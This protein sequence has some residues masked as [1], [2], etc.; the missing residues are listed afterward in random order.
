MILR[1][2]ALLACASSAHAFHGTAR[3][4]P[5]AAPQPPRA[6]PLRATT[7]D[8]ASGLADTQLVLN[9]ACFGFKKRDCLLTLGSGGTATFSAGMISEGPGEWRV[10]SGDP[11][12]GEDARDAYLEFS[13]PITE[14]YSELY[15]VPSGVVFWRGKVA[16][17]GSRMCVVDGIAIS[18]ASDQARKLVGK[19][20]G[21]A[22]FQREGDFTA[23]AVAPGDDPATLPQP[24]SIEL[25]D[26]GSTP[27]SS[28]SSFGDLGT[29]GTRKR[30]RK[31]GTAPDKG[32]G[33]ASEPAAPEAVAAP[34]PVDSGF[35]LPE[36]PKFK[37][38]FE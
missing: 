22:G 12:D 21:S 30:K 1:C 26:D 38:P 15:N 27:T 25:F 23:R 3:A 34:E 11:D 8:A 4:A 24:V 5:L 9:F 10:V 36:L 2:A 28:G 29:R 33:P 17:E 32:F 7:A 31:A 16:S 6:A 18:E 19:L 13:Q 37:N 20:T 14:V 35:S